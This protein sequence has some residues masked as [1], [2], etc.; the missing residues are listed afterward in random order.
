MILMLSAFG[1]LMILFEV[2]CERFLLLAKPRK[3]GES[4]RCANSSALSMSYRM[5]VCC[6][7]RCQ[8]DS[9]NAL[10]TAA[11][12]RNDKKYLAE[13]K[14]VFGKQIKVRTAKDE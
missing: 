14:R 12:A 2:C 9:I 5:R 10:I 13:L 1:L 7:I 6:N 11:V 8:M 4:R 3:S